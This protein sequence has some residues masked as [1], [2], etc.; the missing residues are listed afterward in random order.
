M[1]RVSESTAKK[2]FAVSGNRCAFPK[3]PVPLFDQLSG[4]LTGQIC[5]IRAQSPEGP[6]YDPA[7]TDEDRHSF[8]NLLLLCPV[9]HVVI[10]D[11]DR[12]YTFERL[13]EMKTE[14]ESNFQHGI[15]PSDEVARL[16]V[17][18]SDVRLDHGSLLLAFNQSGG[19]IAHTITNIHAPE[20]RRAA[21][22]EPVIRRVPHERRPEFTTLE[23]RLR[24]TGTAMP[25]DARVTFMMP[26]SMHRHTTQDG[27]KAV[28]DEKLV[29]ERDNAY[30]RDQ[31]L[32]QQLYPEDA[33]THHVLGIH[34][35]LE[36]ERAATATELLEIYVRS[37]DER[38]FACRMTFA[39]VTAMEPNEWYAVTN[40]ANKATSQAIPLPEGAA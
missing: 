10:D 40:A 23:V 5:H 11:D 37:G 38:P 25:T 13:V 34:Y 26:A 8:A 6:R 4:T 29:C 16:L 9:H 36:P 35:Y 30:F 3:C 28:R 2:L 24:N 7:Q 17:S 18:M 1:S 33:T 19:Q 39:Q 15:E 31:N 21:A 14:H 20:A 27:F 22:L 32:F 12:S